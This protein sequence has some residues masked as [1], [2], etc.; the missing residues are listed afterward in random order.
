MWCC[1]Y[2]SIYYADVFVW[3]EL[4]NSLFIYGGYHSDILGLLLMATMFSG[5]AIVFAF[6]YIEMWDDKEGATFIILLAAFLFFMSVLI[7]SNNLFIFYVGW[8]GIGLVSLF[9]INF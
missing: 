9:L 5:S 7:I 8:E 6:V 1:L 3:A 4:G 2:N